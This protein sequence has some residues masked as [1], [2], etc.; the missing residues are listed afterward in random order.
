M[1]I[2]PKWHQMYLAT[3]CCARLLI[4]VHSL[5]YEQLHFALDILRV[6]IDKWGILCVCV[7]VMFLY[8]FI[9]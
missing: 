1:G 7:C 5:A 8:T 4:G 9:N 3:G 6:A 2:R